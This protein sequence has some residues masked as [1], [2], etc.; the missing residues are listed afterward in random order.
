MPTVRIEI[1]DSTKIIIPVSAA[2]NCT[3]LL[4][5]FRLLSSSRLLS[6]FFTTEINPSTPP[7]RCIS[8][9]KEPT[10]RVK[11]IVL[12]FPASLKT[13]TKELSVSNDPLSKLPSLIITHPIQMPRVNDKNTCLVRSARTIAIM[14]G[15]RDQNP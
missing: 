13:V 15:R 10:K 7:D 2:I 5:P 9:I 8:A 6:L 4:L 12:V 11:I 1:L 3:F 14:G